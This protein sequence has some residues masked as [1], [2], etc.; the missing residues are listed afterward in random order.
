LAIGSRVCLEKV[1]TTSP[2]AETSVLGEAIADRAAAHCALRGRRLCSAAEV[3]RAFLCYAHDDGRF[4]A[5]GVDTAQDLGELRC[6]TTADIV[7]TADGHSALHA[8]RLDGTRL[9]FETDAE[10]A[11]LPDCPEYRCCHDL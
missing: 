3:R 11:D 7:L 4:C 1:G 9:V 10:I 8:S 5:P 2:A 6:W